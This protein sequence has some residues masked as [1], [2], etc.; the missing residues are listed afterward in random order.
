LNKITGKNEPSDLLEAELR[1]RERE[2]LEL[3][4]QNDHLK[5]LAELYQRQGY[6]GPYDVVPGPVVVPSPHPVVSPP[7]GMGTLS[8]VILGTGTGGRDDDGIP[9]D[10]SLQVVIV[11]KDDD[12][13]AVKLAGRVSILAQEITREGLKVSIGKWEVTPEQLKK[14]WRGGLLGSG[15]FVPLQWDRP[16][17][18]E[19]VRITIRFTTPDGRVYEADKDATVRPLP[20][21]VPRAVMPIPSGPTG[22]VV[23]MPPASTSSPPSSS[24]LAPPE[25]PSPSSL[26]PAPRSVDDSP[27]RLKPAVPK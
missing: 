21:L 23:P 18:T 24:I 19:K 25:F 14:A 10:E 13:A 15:Y 20:G 16:P 6:P 27:A 3:R 1:T 2:I 9:G 22:D 26:L 8:E 5:Q 11:P 7:I 17:T 12:G 4:S